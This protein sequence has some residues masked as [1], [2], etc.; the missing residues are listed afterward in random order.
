MGGNGGHVKEEPLSGWSV[1]C[2]MAVK[3]WLELDGVFLDIDMICLWGPATVCLNVV[4]WGASEGECSSSAGAHLMAGNI[5]AEAGFQLLDELWVCRD[6]TCWSE[7]ERG[8]HWKASVSRWQIVEK[9]A[10]GEEVAWSSFN[11]DSAALKDTISLWV[12]STKKKMKCQF[13]WVTQCGL[14]K[15]VFGGWTWLSWLT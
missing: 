3:Q 4:I 5:M 10:C 9:W 1:K 12:G 14:S 2:R 13:D 15:G 6:F 7:P 11:N 8:V